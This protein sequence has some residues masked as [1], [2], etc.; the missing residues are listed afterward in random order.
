MAEE[1]LET[2]GIS[3][4]SWHI[5]F[6]PEERGHCQEIADLWTG[7][8]L[9]WSKLSRDWS[10]LDGLHV[11]PN[12]LEH[13]TASLGSRAISLL[14]WCTESPIGG[15]ESG[16][17]RARA[18]CTLFTCRLVPWT[19]AHGLCRPIVWS[20]IGYNMHFHSYSAIIMSW[21]HTSES[22][23]L[24][25][26]RRPVAQWMHKM[27]SR[28]SKPIGPTHVKY[29]V[30]ILIPIK[31]LHFARHFRCKV[32]ENFIKMCEISRGEASDRADR[33]DFGT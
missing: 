30:I 16:D 29:W 11:H 19:S 32:P 26:R 4:R 2:T 5:Y 31:L 24:Y 33:E 9:H 17:H 6:Q 3:C 25:I 8:P 12:D 10:I 22:M 15:V 20:Y 1:N 27:L 28:W 7:R 18:R 21:I 23:V 13:A 14:V